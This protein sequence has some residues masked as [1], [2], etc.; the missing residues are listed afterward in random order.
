MT[1]IST[2][3]IA[4]I[5][6]SAPGERADYPQAVATV[7]RAMVEINTNPAEGIAALRE[8]LA[9]LNDHAPQ[10]AEDPRALELRAMAELALARALLQSG[11]REAAAVIVDRALAGLGDAKLPLDQLGPSLGAL[12][13]ERQRA[14]ADRGHAR[15]RIACAVPCRVYV[16]ERRSSAADEIGAALLVGEH[17][18]WIESEEAEPLRT[19]ITLDDQATLTIAYPEWVP[20]APAPQLLE[21]APTRRDRRATHGSRGAL[22]SAG[23][24]TA[25]LGSAAAIAGAVLWALDSK[26]PRGADPSDRVACPQLYDTRTAGIALVSAGGATALLGGVL[27]VVNASSHGERRGHELALTWTARF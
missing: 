21:P 16:D 24:A 26:C 6:A 25:V 12:V 2:L 19:T 9:S 7:E 10:L 14:L 15:L 11:D 27:L 8:A 22:R 23:I 5:L 18:V 3:S 4:L 17:R 13:Q 20:A 1:I